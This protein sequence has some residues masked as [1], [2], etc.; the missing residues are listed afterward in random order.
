MSEIQQETEFEQITIKV[1]KILISVLDTIG[2]LTGQDKIYFINDLLYHELRTICE[3]PHYLF[4][5]YLYRD[6]SECVTNFEKA[7]ELWNEKLTEDLNQ[8]KYHKQEVKA[9]AST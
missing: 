4:E 9:H 2:A 8:E 3:E 1:P 5:Y 7:M 6:S